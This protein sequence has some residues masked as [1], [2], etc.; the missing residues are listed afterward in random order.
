MKYLMAPIGLA[1]F[2]ENANVPPDQPGD[3]LPQGAVEA[4]S[5]S[6]LPSQLG[7]GLGLG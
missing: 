4:F 7:Q 5:L 6:G 2:F 1:S 3:P